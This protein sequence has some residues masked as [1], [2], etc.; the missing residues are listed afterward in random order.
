MQLIQSHFF[1]FD[2]LVIW[3]ILA[4]AFLCYGLLIELCFVHAASALWYERTQYWATSIRHMLGALPLLGL[5]GTISGLLKTFVRMSIEKGFALQ[6]IISGGI[7]E[8]MFTTQLGLI[9][10][11]PGLLMLVFLTHKKKGWVIQQAHEINN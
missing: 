2:N 4:T 1:L 7:A 9:M 5:L 10:V 11:V 6:E 3:A 8:A